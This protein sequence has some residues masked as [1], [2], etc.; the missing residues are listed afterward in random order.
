MSNNTAWHHKVP[1]ADQLELALDE[2]TTVDRQDGA[3]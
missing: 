2:L 3:A 1:S